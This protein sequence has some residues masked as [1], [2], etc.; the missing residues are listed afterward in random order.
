MSVAYWRRKDKQFCSRSGDS[1]AVLICTCPI[2]VWP[3]ELFLPVNKSKKADQ[4]Q[5]VLRLARPF[6]SLHVGCMHNY[7]N[8]LDKPPMLRTG[9][10]FGICVPGKKYTD[11]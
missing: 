9:A 3:S 1:K 6:M 5:V 8:P 2:C 11:G 4:Q 10:G 7:Y